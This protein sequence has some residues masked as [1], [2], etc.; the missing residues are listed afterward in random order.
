MFVWLRWFVN[1]V[2]C[3]PTPCNAARRA[4]CLSCA[5]DPG[6]ARVDV[7]RE[8]HQNL[9]RELGQAKRRFWLG[10]IREKLAAPQGSTIAINELVMNPENILELLYFL[11]TFTYFFQLHLSN[12]PGKGSCFAH[13]SIQIPIA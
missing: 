1:R 11:F 2:T 6:H 5:I 10:L 7:P 8:S 12:E 3:L 4:G 13:L 9:G